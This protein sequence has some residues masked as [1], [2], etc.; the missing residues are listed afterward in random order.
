VEF[1]NER[2][3]H[4]AVEMNKTEGFHAAYESAVDKVRSDF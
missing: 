2:T 1:R 3:W 4:N